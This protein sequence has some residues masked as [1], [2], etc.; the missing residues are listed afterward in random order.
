[1]KKKHQK[2]II[3]GVVG[4][5]LFAAIFFTLGYIAINSGE[6]MFGWILASLNSPAYIILEV[7]NSDSN[8]LFYLFI[9]IYWFIIGFCIFTGIYWII[10]NIKKKTETED[11]GGSVPPQI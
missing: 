6:S 10:T 5:L 1:M 8:L 2:Y 3:W 9:F 7:C 4:G 11:L